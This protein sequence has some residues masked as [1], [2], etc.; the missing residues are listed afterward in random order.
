[1]TTGI[2]L[3]L[4]FMGVAV[5]QFLLLF[6]HEFGHV[7]PVLATG[8]TAQITIGS[9]DGRTV[10][11]G[12]IRFTIGFKTVQSLF[13]YGTVNWWGVE[14][15][16]IHAIAILSGPLMS[17]TMILISGGALL[18]GVDSPLYWIFV[19]LVFLETWRLYQ[20]IVPKTYSRGPYEGMPSD[21]KRFLQLIRS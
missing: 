19:N 18:G 4:I 3:L 20:T 11:S 21:G 9:P 6:L 7:I 12:P 16:R 13:I 2:E 1:M 10:Q 15:D 8:G 14:S 5:G 17:L